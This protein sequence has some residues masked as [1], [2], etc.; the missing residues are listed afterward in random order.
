[1]PLPT[2]RMA[3]RRG[4]TRTAPLHQQARERFMALDGW[5]VDLADEHDLDLGTIIW[6]QRALDDALYRINR[7]IALTNQVDPEPERPTKG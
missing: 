5:L 6:A 3:F 2:D 4:D 1:M 7:A